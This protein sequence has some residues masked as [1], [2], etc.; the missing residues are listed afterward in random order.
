[1]AKIIRIIINTM[2]SLL[3]I[4]LAAVFLLPRAFGYK[5][6]V[7]VSASM[8]QSFPVGSLIFVH[9][10]QPQDISVGDP[11]TFT[12]ANMVITHRVIAIDNGQQ[13]FTTKG[14]NNLISEKVPFA[15]L[16][17]RAL[18]FSIPYVGY[19]SAW[20]MTGNGKLAAVCIIGSLMLMSLML[21]RIEDQT[22]TTNPKG[23]RRKRVKADEEC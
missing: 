6:Y 5:P 14:D 22:G 19:V 18:N 12:A 2:L 15:D 3:L 8:Q 9:D 4:A 11:I 13:V 23:K 10:A 16:R 7:V 17:G 21:G 20:L 1:M